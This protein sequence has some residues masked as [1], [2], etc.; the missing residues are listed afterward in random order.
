MSKIED[1]TEVNIQAAGKA[2]RGGDH[3]LH[4]LWTIKMQLNREANYDLATLADRANAKALRLG[5][6]AAPVNTL[7]TGSA[8]PKLNPTP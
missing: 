8:R 6:L 4:E 5:F 2:K 1:S 7:S 3:V